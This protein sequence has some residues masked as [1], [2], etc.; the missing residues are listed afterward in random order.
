VR[1]RGGGGG[2]GG[3]GRAAAQK[4]LPV[5]SYDEIVELVAA[6]C[7]RAEKGSERPLGQKESF[8]LRGRR[9]NQKLF[10]RR[11]H[12]EQSLIVFALSAEVA[13]RF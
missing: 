9:K 10:E 12:L 3:G 8:V 5:V 2:G 13:A 11:L 6:F 1:S 4:K 7:N